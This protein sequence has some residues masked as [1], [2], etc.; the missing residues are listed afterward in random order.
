M[1]Y[2]PP[3]TYPGGGAGPYATGLV[4]GVRRLSRRP[5]ARLF[6]A[7]AYGDTDIDGVFRGGNASLSIVLKEW[8][9]NIRAML[10]PFGGNNSTADFGAIGVANAPGIGKLL[11]DMAGQIILTAATGTPAAGTLGPATITFAKAIMS[12]DTDI[13][14][15]MGAEPRDIPVVFKLFPYLD[16]SS[17]VRFWSMT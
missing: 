14:I 10:W 1:T 5:Q 8:T 16:G 9:A 3:A 2:E 6:Q 11:T 12:P 15:L 17:I 7:D 13:E 4:E